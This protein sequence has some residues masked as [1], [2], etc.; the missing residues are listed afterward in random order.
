MDGS[1]LAA[2]ESF[3]GPG[4]SPARSCQED[5]PEHAVGIAMKHLPRLRKSGAGLPLLPL[6]LRGCVL[7]TVNFM[8]HLCEL[9]PAAPSATREAGNTYLQCD[10]CSEHNIFFA[11]FCISEDKTFMGLVCSRLSTELQG[12]TSTSSAHSSVRSWPLKRHDGCNF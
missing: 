12:S 10:W 8:A 11:T 7:F 9:K 1:Q 3:S 5:L 4:S 6:A 2:A